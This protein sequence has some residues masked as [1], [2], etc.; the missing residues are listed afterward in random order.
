MNKFMNRISSD[1]KICH[2]KP[3]IKD[4]RILVSVILDNLAEGLTIKEI[5]AEY[6]ELKPE[7]IK[8]AIAY[9]A[10]LAREEDLVPLRQSMLK[11]K[12]DENLGKTAQKV[13]NDAGY[14]TERPSDE[15]ISGYADEKIWEFVCK[16]KLFFITLDSDFSDIRKFPP[17]SHSGILILR[18]ANQSREIVGRTLTK[19]IKECPIE[20]LKGCLTVADESHT[21]IRRPKA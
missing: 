13:L 15:G 5:I 7:D 21:R 6:P 18:L 3:C 17:G 4:T 10:E 1:P 2:G 11:I 9:A 12:L 16:E 8:A 20:T 19:I 14:K